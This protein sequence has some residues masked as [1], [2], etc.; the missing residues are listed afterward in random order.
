VQLGFS[1]YSFY[2]RLSG[3]SMS[4]LDVID[5]VADNGGQHLELAAVYPAADSP[6]PTPDSASAFVEAVRDRSAARGI[7]LSSLAIGARFDLE[8][9]VASEIRRVKDWIDLAGR[10]G[11]ARLRHDVVPH[12]VVPGDDSVAFEAVL[13][14]VVQAC[15]EIADYAADQGVTTS[16]ENH[17]FFVQSSER[18]RRIVHAVDRPNFRT[19]LDVGNFLC[20]DEDPVTAV[21]ANLPYAMVVHLKDFYVRPAAFAA[22]DGWFASRGGRHL[23]GAI[24]GEGDIDM[25]AVVGAIRA[26][27]FDGFVAIEFEGLE[28][29][30]IGCARGLATARRLWEAAA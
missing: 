29:C 14:A 12:A 20:V 3:G 30:L 2:Q 19:T 18:V 6:V 26:S 17:G 16:I 23:R 5:W 21:A 28:D 24:V 10:L 27:G 22:P 13:P 8:S 4:L 9:E 7:P 25:P 1:S 11:I 15:R